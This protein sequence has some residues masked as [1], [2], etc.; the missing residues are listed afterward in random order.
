MFRFKFFNENKKSIRIFCLGLRKNIDI[1][2]K[3][4]ADD[5]R[6]AAF[7]LR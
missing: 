6:G 5:V 3:K 2:Q 1:Q 4:K 7:K